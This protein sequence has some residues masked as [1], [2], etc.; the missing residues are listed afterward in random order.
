MGRTQNLKPWPKGVSGGNENREADTLT[1]SEAILKFLEGA[2]ESKTEPEIIGAVE[3]RTLTARGAIRQLVDQGKVVRSGAG[4]RGSPYRYSFPLSCSQPVAA[5]QEIQEAAGTSIST[6]R[7][8]V[9]RKSQS[10]FSS[11]AVRWGVRR[12]RAIQRYIPKP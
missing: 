10:R 8:L 1:V 4:R 3:R 2:S 7:N 12:L 5:E 6:E 11:P 9:P